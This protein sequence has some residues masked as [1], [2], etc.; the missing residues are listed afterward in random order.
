MAECQFGF[1]ESLRAWPENRAARAGLRACLERMARYEVGHENAPRAEALLA[2]I[3]DPPADLQADVAA[4]RERV[5][6]RAERE[7]RLR[8]I[9]RQR[10][11]TTGAGPRAA[12][13]VL[14]FGLALA[15]WRFAVRPD[16]RGV[17]AMSPERMALVLG[18]GVALI[19]ALGLLL[20]RTFLRTA[21]TR[22]LVLGM[23]CCFL[24]MLANRSLYVI[25]APV[26]AS[27]VA[28]D[29]VIAATA[30]AV[31]AVTL[32]R[33]LWWLVPVFLAAALGARLWPL[34]AGASMGLALAAALLLSLRALGGLP[35]T[36]PRE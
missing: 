32:A 33:W 5:A 11:W 19:T 13:L 7:A 28:G 27:M 26:T 8:E 36:P 29:M 14:A 17:D 22:S 23:L 1:Q 18:A 3:A 30:A 21:V 9:E 12:F 34:H 2:Q 25:R 24:G 16:E 6:R 15:M 31:G 20:R 35:R 4:L 10:D